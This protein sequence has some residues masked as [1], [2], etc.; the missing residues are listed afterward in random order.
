MK[1]ATIAVILT[2]SLFLS[3]CGKKQETSVSE[4]EITTPVNEVKSSENQVLIDKTNRISL[5]VPDLFIL[6]PEDEEN[7]SLVL[8]AHN[9]FN[10]LVLSVRHFG[11]LKVEAKQYFSQL[12][13]MIKEQKDYENARV[14]VATENRMNYYFIYSEDDEKI[15]ESCVAIIADE[16]IYS[17]CAN[18][19]KLSFDEM[20]TYLKDIRIVQ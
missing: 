1:F 10:D 19:S 4:Q 5:H 13:K 12:N 8:S 15:K 9:Q 6:D 2:T 17:V 3:A 16:D 18:S 20:S 14:G 11:K 7:S